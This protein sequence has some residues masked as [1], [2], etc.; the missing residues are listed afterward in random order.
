MHY[1][2]NTYIRDRVYPIGYERKNQKSKK[3]LI[4]LLKGEEKMTNQNANPVPTQ[5][6]RVTMQTFEVTTEINTTVTPSGQPQIMPSAQ[7]MGYQQGF[8]QPYFPQGYGPGQ[9]FYGQPYYAQYPQGVIPQQG[10]PQFVPSLGPNGQVIGYVPVTQAPV[11]AQAAPAVAAPAAAVVTQPAA[12]AAAAVTPPPATP[13]QQN[14]F[15]RNLKALIIAAV[16]LILF[17][18]LLPFLTRAYND[19]YNSTVSNN[20]VQDANNQENANLLATVQAMQAAEAARAAQPQATPQAAVVIPQ[21]TDD[22]TGGGTP[23]VIPVVVGVNCFERATLIGAPVGS[24]VCKAPLS[25]APAQP[26]QAGS[27]VGFGSITFDSETRVW[28]LENFIVPSTSANY[29][30]DYTGREQNVLDAPF[31]TG[32]QVSPVNQQPFNICWD[33][34]SD[35][36]VPPAAIEFYQ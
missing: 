3:F 35:G 4:N 11:V 31:V 24:N 5:G 12:A 16:A 28:I 29:S 2:S 7:Q 13:P 19:F 23:D 20:Q 30:Y 25:G 22:Q 21:M 18:L 36:C 33:V 8:A 27:R 1:V 6:H 26:V 32:G 14:W 15:K 34:T 10:Q 17:I 9:P